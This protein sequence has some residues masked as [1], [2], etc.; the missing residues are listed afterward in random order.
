MGGQNH[1]RLL[2]DFGQYVL[3]A[4][5]LRRIEPRRGFINNQQRRIAQQG[6]RDTITLLHAAGKLI[7]TLVSRVPQIGLDQQPFHD[8]LLLT[9][10]YA[11]QRREVFEHCERG[12]AR[13]G[14]E[15]LRQIAECAA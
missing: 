3:E 7:N 1:H 11:L 14:A 12:G 4:P 8:L 9:A 10:V 2:A 5:P 6:L 13:V 15:L